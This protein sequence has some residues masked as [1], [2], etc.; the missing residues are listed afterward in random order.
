VNFNYFIDELTSDYIIEAVNLIARD[1]WRLLPDYSFEPETGLW[2]HHDHRLTP[3]YG[4]DSLR[5]DSG[6]PEHD[7]GHPTASTDA[8]AGYLDEARRIFDAAADRQQT[9]SDSPCRL[10]GVDAERL[11]WFPLP[12]EVI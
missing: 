9:T 7:S 5:Y 12:G 10:A 11:R 4:L 6:R 8:L 1:G 3:T 2:R